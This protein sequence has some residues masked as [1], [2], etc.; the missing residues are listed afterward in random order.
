M[1]WKV[2]KIKKREKGEKRPG[3]LAIT[4]TV[5]IPCGA[6]TATVCVVL[7]H[8]NVTWGISRRVQELSRFLPVPGP[9]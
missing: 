8:L 7:S 3:V 4:A 6:S 2:V 9:A 1:G 5:E